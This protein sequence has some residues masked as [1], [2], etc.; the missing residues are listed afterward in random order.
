MR[1]TL[2]GNITVTALDKLYSDMRAGRA[3]CL[4]GVC[5]SL[6]GNY[7]HVE[8]FNPAGSGITALVC[9][10]IFSCGAGDQVNLRTHNAALSTDGGAGV[11]ML[12]GGAAGVCHVYTERNVALLGTAVG[13][14]DVLASTPVKFDPGWIAE[15]PAGRGVIVV[16]NTA[17]EAAKALFWW[18]E[19]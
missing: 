18:I 7:S 13:G 2:G 19:L 12:L 17:N 15:L 8:L 1:V 5:V 11:N 4:G 6:A 14:L 9:M 16:P 3:F 10:A